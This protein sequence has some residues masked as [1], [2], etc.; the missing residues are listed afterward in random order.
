MHCNTNGICTKDV[1]QVQDP[2][3]MPSGRGSHWAGKEPDPETKSSK[4]KNQIQNEK[5]TE[6]TFM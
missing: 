4:S 2:A 1:L 6:V 3:E 5:E